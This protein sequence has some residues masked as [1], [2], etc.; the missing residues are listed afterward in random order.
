MIARVRRALLAAIVGALSAALCLVAAYMV[1]PG[2]EFEM[3]RPLPS[4]V[5]G[6]SGNE[7]DGRVSF[8][9]SSGRVTAT[10]PGLDRQVEWS[11]T[12][13]F[14]GPRP[15]GLAKPSV[16]VI[17]DGR[18][19]TP[20]QATDEYLEQGILLPKESSDGAQIVVIVSPTFVPG[21]ADTRELGV[22]VDRLV[23]RPASTIVRPPSNT[24]GRA[25][26]AAGIFSAG[27]A[28]LGLSLSSA[29]F[30]AVA[31][32]F[33]QTVML[34]IASGMY[35]SYSSRFPWL[36]LSIVLST[37]V[38]ARVVEYFRRQPLSSSAR[39]VLAASASVLFLKL[40]GLYHPAKPIIDSVFNG[41]NLQR[42]LE[43]GRW[44]FTQPLPNGVAMP[45]AVGLY[46]FS[47]PFTWLSSNY[48]AIVWTV[49]ASAD[50]IAGALLYPVILHAWGDRR[51]AAA[52]AVLFQ[53]VPAPFVTLGN[54]NLPNMFGQALA[55]AAVAAAVMWRLDVRKIGALA[56]LTVLVS[57]ALLSHVSTVTM[58]PAL[59]GALVLLYWWRGDAERRRTALAIVVA[60]GV[61]AVVAWL[62]YYRH[63]LDVFKKAFTL[64]FSEPTAEQVAA[65][66]AVKGN[67]TMAGRLGNLG[68]Q[69][70]EGFGPPLLILAAFGVW[71]LWRRHRRD[72]LVSALIA[73]A[74]FWAIFS[75]STVFARVDAA[76]VR[77]TAEFIGRINLA[78]VPLIAILAGRGAMF[79]WESEI[80]HSA[81]RPL[82]VLAAV[83]VA[84]T[85]ALALQQWLGWFTR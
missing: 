42:L 81:R 57:A 72:R 80:G 10:I 59:L 15:D 11:C 32:G 29:L 24:L 23:C 46:V 6:M 83:L 8:A 33:G 41:H 45:Y 9:W 28:L 52:A 53:L 48:T 65:A 21:G 68:Q 54:A 2:L 73:W 25:A 55:L 78:T 20:I 16:Q 34:A 82:Q 39:F 40:A 56:G 84:W 61:A 35:G 62:L 58:L 19:S 66:A 31:V 70:I 4:F 43:Q 49:T 36:A 44:L 79:G 7:W 75:A 5:Q 64:M 26:L 18:A 71:S 3:D 12:L 1:H 50:V 69:A 63:F 30:A 47:A 60:S 67:M 22:Q 14:R 37:L 74:V 85:I 13:R 76:Y 17:V 77:Y 38:L 27:L 51:A